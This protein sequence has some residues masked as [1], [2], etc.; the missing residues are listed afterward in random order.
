MIDI[1]AEIAVQTTSP[2]EAVAWSKAL[3]EIFDAWW[4]RALLILSV[5]VNMGLLTSKGQSMANNLNPLNK[6]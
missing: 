5:L 6:K 2:E 4:D 1:L 3:G